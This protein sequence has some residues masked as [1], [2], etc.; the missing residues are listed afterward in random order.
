LYLSN[1]LE[2]VL[3]EDKRTPIVS[4]NIWYHV[5]S[6]DEPAHRNGFA[7]LFEHVMFQGTKHI[8][9]DTWFRYLERVGAT[10]VNG[11]TNQDRTNYFETIPSNR[12]ELALWMESDRMGFLLDHVDQKTF[13]SQREVVKNER[14]QNYE[15]APYGLV[16]QYVEA[17]IYPEAHP[18]HLLTI[19]TPE[20][21]DN[22]TLDD[23]KSFFRTWYV[24]NNATL[25]IA[26]DFDKA[27]AKQLVE[28]YFGPI[29][30]G[31]LPARRP[32]PPVR[33]TGE[34]RIEMR[35]GVE[36]GRVY[37]AWPTPAFFKPGDGELDLVAHVLTAGKTSRLYKRLVYDMQIAQ[38]VAAWQGSGLLG[39]KFEIEATAKPG[40]TP[41]ELL[42]AIDEEL[43][44]ART[45]GVSDAELARAKTVTLA[46]GVFR[47]EHDGSRAD[48]LNTYD[49]Y[50]GDPGYLAQ[51][52]ARYQNA[53]ADGV[54]SAMGTYLTPNRVVTIV[55]PV[56]GAPICGEL[57]RTRTSP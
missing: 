21:L 11:T 33:L 40:H 34:T 30:S 22:A 28:K 57:V 12:L 52:V 5:G 4:V 51:D 18:Y 8:P 48:M 36:L 13:A 55:N 23:V 31:V 32:V 20:D 56:N 1:G 2:V 44:K 42:K 39:S 54:R 10:D 41:D 46:S 14:R 37:L 9:E 16:P 29:P 38:D 47:L 43:E 24:P 3:H 27:N 49:L 45:G 17:A 15:N 35:A 6:K 53:T 7:H 25:V 50:T 19:G 26:G